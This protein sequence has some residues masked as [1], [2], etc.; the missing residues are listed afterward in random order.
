MHIRYLQAILAGLFLCA[1]AVAFAADPAVPDMRGTW[2]VEAISIVTGAGNHHPA[3]APPPAEGTKPRLRKFEATMQ[4]TG[5]EG[6]RFWG[7]LTSKAY[8]EDV[9][10]TF[11]GEGERF[12]AVNSAGYF[13]G[14]VLASGSARYCYQQV[15]PTLH[16]AACGTMTRE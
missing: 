5:Q 6:V 7:T 12:I 3:D 9:I 10:A 1:P 11:T 16:V 4:V 8:K 2:K 14:N 13:S 15:E